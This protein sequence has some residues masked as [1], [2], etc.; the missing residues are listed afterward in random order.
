[1]S[2]FHQHGAFSAL[3]HEWAG[4]TAGTQLKLWRQMTEAVIA[5]PM[6]QMRAAHSLFEL[7]RTILGLAVPQ[8]A[9]QK[10]ATPQNA[11]PAAPVKESTLVSPAV[12]GTQ[13]P[14]GQSD[15]K[16][17]AKRKAIARKPAVRKTAEQRPAARAA[18]G[19]AAGEKTVPAEAA[20]ATPEVSKPVAVK[21]NQ[22][23][24]SATGKPDTDAA[25]EPA[26]VFRGSAA[27]RRSPEKQQNTTQSAAVAAVTKSFAVKTPV[28]E[29]EP[30]AAK[31]AQS[32]KAAPG[33]R[34]RKP[35]KP[36][37]MPARNAGKA[38]ESKE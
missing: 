33:K 32:V 20:V 35:S 12:K 21:A 34:P 14:A 4:Y 13:P 36:R 16:P 17:A 26:A 37:K 11:Q 25:A 3:A 27:S 22:A 28:P 2:S 7:Q 8:P 10:T 1:M 5:T 31:P 30:L 18:A 23:K 9:W 29:T 19:K 24:A 6:G 38:G 15:A